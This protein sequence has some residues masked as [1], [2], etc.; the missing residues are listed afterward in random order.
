V[1]YLLESETVGVAF[2]FAACGPG[3]ARAL[4]AGL[5]QLFAALPAQQP[6]LAQLR[7]QRLQP[8]AALPQDLLDLNDALLQVLVDLPLRLQ[9]LRQR[10]RP[11]NG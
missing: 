7:L 1:E 11:L 4:L 10:A 2:E 8:V 6:S 5:L 3:P 9:L